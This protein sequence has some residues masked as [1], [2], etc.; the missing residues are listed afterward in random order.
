MTILKINENL[1]YNLF[2]LVPPKEVLIMDM[3]G[4]RLEGVI[5]PYDE[6]SQVLLI[7]EAEGGL[8][9]IF[10]IHFSLINK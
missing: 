6:D 10:I 9:S 3:E 8:K 4:Q 2:C 1:T 7:C 5:G